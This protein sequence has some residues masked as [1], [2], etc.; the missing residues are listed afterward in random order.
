MHIHIG[1]KG[2]L[3]KFFQKIEDGRVQIAEILN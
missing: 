1:Q 2:I 3:L